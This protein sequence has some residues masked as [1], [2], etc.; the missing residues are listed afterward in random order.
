MRLEIQVECPVETKL[1]NYCQQIDKISEFIS[2]H[3]LHT[4]VQSYIYQ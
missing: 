4:Y 3:S 2:Q 1:M